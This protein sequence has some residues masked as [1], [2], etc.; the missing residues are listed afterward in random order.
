MLHGIN[1][2]NHSW[3]CCWT[4]CCLKTCICIA[5]R[6]GQTFGQKWQATPRLSTCRLSMWLTMPC[7]AF[8][9]YSHRW[10]CHTPSGLLDISCWILRSKSGNKCDWS[11]SCLWN[12]DLWIIKAF[13]VGHCLWQRG[14]ENPDELICLASTWF[15]TWEI[16]FELYPHSVHCQQP[17]SFLNMK[18]FTKMFRPSMVSA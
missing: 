12:L 10:H 5:W 8:V 1:R 14:Q 13:L 9:V 11:Y 15:W 3:C 7:L 4:W 18:L 17:P 6:V 2:I 16:F